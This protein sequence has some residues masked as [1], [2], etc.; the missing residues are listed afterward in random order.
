ML[1]STTSLLT[2]AIATLGVTAAPAGDGGLFT[3][4]NLVALLTLTALEIILGIDNIVFIAILVAKLP[5]HLQAKA[6]RIGLGLAMFIRVLLLLA[7]GWIMRLT[8]PLFHLP[9]F[10]TGPEGDALGISGRDLILI[11]GGLFLLGKATYEIHDKLEGAHTFPGGPDAARAGTATFARTIVQV[12]LLDIVFS[13]DSVITAVGMASQVP[14]MIAAVIIAV[15]V[16]LVFAGPV[17]NFVERHPTIKMLALSFL[18]LI[19]LMLVVEGFH[20][21][22]P[23]GYVYFAMAFSL[24][25]ELL[26]LRLRKASK[27]VH[28]HQN[29]VDT[30]G[31]SGP[32]VAA[33]ATANPQ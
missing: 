6:R 25:V 10:W 9:K 31:P 27:P 8:E 16:M 33:S 22:I 17:S 11:I 28:L 5:A 2:C 3:T 30:D 4:E 18:L 14:I 7:I 15:G 13:L 1:I 29:Y 32:A 20:G 24:A 21:H 26:N 12:L 19:G 23:K